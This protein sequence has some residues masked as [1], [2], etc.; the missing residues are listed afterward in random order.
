MC[1][2]VEDCLHGEDE[3]TEYCQEH[4]N[5]REGRQLFTLEDATNTMHDDNHENTAIIGAVIFS[6]GILPISAT[7]STIT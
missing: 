1:D 2:G 7:T 5:R 6:I 3:D 4:N